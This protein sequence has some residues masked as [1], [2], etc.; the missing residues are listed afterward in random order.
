[1]KL[2]KEF[3]FNYVRHHSSVPLPEYFDVADELGIFVQHELPIAYDRFLDG[4]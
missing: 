2:I 3:G 1:M 4:V